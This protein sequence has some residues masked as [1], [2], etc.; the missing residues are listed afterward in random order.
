[1]DAMRTPC[2]SFETHQRRPSRRGGFTLVELLVSVGIIAA[3]AGL[4]VGAATAIGRSQQGQNTVSVMNQA[5][6]TASLVAKQSPIPPDH[7]LANFFWVQ[8]HTAGLGVSPTFDAGTA[9]RMS[10]AEF[11]AFLALS[12]D[13]TG[14]MLRLAGNAYLKAPAPSANWP[15]SWVSGSHAWPDGQGNLL[16]DVF[17]QNAAQQDIQFKASCPTTVR[18][19]PA[20]GASQFALM[21]GVNGCLLLSLFDGWGR[22]LVYRAYA[23]PDILSG[24][25]AYYTTTPTNGQSLTALETIAGDAQTSPARAD[26]ASGALQPAVAAANHPYF[27][28]AGP[29]G[30][31]GSFKDAKERDA[32]DD[33]S[34][35]RDADARDNVYSIDWEGR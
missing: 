20:P 4:I 10:S 33:A 1:M 11:F 5:V 15:A 23:H 7:R 30:L 32:S 9:R 6:L 13:A 12:G 31:W 25:D 19:I 35:A 27:F 3:L 21:T 16:V 17:Q 24:S 8:P 22:E 28:S 18:G 2:P 29:D 34:S 14:K 26:K